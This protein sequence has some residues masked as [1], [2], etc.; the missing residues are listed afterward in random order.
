M[1]RCAR[2]TLTAWSPLFLSL[3]CVCCACCVSERNDSRAHHARNLFTTMLA[4]LAKLLVLLSL[5][6]LAFTQASVLAGVPSCAVSE[7]LYIVVTLPLTLIS[8]PASWIHSQV[9]HHHVPSQIRRASV[10]AAPSR[11]TSRH[12]CW[13]AA[14]SRRPLRHSTSA[15]RHAMRP[16]EMTES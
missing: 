16:S 11:R 3:V 15:R 14:P 8:S 12:V 1:S 5:V 6:Q 7:I 10:R 2:V 9:Q 13:R 4:P